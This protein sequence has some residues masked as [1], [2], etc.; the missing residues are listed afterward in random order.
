[1]LSKEECEQFRYDFAFHLTDAD[2]DLM[3]LTAMSQEA[4]GWSPDEAMKK[5]I[6]VL[7]HVIPHLNA[8]GRILLGDVNDHFENDTSAH[9]LKKAEL[10]SSDA[11]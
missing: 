1:M 9:L 8:S 10:V 6:G 5:L 3:L 2:A 11:S 4:E 7:Y